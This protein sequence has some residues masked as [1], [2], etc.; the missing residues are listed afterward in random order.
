MYK[1]CGSSRSYKR[2][3]VTLCSDSLMTYYPSFQACIDNVYGKAIDLAHVTVKIPGKKPTGLKSL[4]DVN[5]TSYPLFDRTAHVNVISPDLSSV[6][7][8]KKLVA[9]EN[10]NSL[11]ELII[12]SLDNRQWQFQ[13]C[14]QNELSEWVTAIED[15][16]K[17]SLLKN[18]DP[19]ESSLFNIK[20]N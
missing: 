3:Y 17:N 9:D 4:D 8:L 6:E 20:G 11:H 12:I 1:K 2:K 5:Q 10:E 19:K 15:Q 16:I 18:D 13:L 14:S 7:S